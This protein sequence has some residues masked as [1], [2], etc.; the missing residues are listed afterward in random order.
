MLHDK[1]IRKS[2]STI[3]SCVMLDAALGLG[4]LAPSFEKLLTANLVM[5]F[6]H[7]LP[8]LSSVDGRWNLKSF[9]RLFGG[10][11]R[12]FRYES[13]REIH[14]SDDAYVQ[15]DRCSLRCSARYALLS[16]FPPTSPCGKHGNWRILNELRTVARGHIL[17]G[18]F[19]AF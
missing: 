14:T 12:Y 8:S 5:K 17:T 11:D 1:D 18:S 4:V 7:R 19:K 3:P 10:R 16:C 15:D 6:C 9:V 2:V 13:R